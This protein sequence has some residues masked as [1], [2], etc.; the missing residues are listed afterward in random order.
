MRPMPMIMRTTTRTSVLPKL[1]RGHLEAAWTGGL[2]DLRPNDRQC[3]ILFLEVYLEPWIVSDSDVSQSSHVLE[4][5]SVRLSST[6]SIVLNALSSVHPLVWGNST[7][8]PQHSLIVGR[9]VR[10]WDSARRRRAAASASLW[11]RGRDRRRAVRVR[12]RG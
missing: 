5:V 2:E 4:H 3:A 10:T 8:I 1:C 9:C 11:P 12:K 7:R 6:L